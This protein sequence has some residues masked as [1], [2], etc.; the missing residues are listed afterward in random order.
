MEKTEYEKCLEAR[1][2]AEKIIKENGWDKDIR[3]MMELRHAL[4]HRIDK[5]NRDCHSGHRK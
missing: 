5:Y 4:Q 1:E 3:F 2:K